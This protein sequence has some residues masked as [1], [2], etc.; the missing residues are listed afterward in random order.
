[1]I[2]D[3]AT[4]K[5]RSTQLDLTKVKWAL[6]TPDDDTGGVLIEKDR[7]IAW[8]HLGT[9]LAETAFNSEGKDY[10]QTFSTKSSVYSPFSRIS[11]SVP[12]E[13]KVGEVPL[14]KSPILLRTLNAF[15]DR[16][17]LGIDAR[18]A[19]VL[20]FDRK[21]FAMTRHSQMIVDLPL[22]PRDP[23]GEPTKVETQILREKL[24]RSLKKIVGKPLLAGVTTRPNYF[25]E[26]GAQFL[27]WS[28]AD[29]FPLFTASCQEQ[30][31]IRC[32]F[33]RACDVTLG[34]NLQ[35]AE[36]SGLAASEKRQRLYVGNRQRQSIEIFRGSSC[37]NLVHE[38]S[39]VLPEQLGSLRN[40]YI[41]ADDRLWVTT[42]SPDNYRNA[43]AYAW[44]SVDW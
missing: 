44:E 30:D 31:G 22:P 43:S 42:Q 13:A 18:D 12:Q 21:T 40:I 3:L 10:K 41:D 11:L 33:S 9:T 26:G 5:N 4:A 6:M 37:L 14:L 28:H 38:G 20:S 23:R 7:I 25:A 27:V 29:L 15:S 19:Q 8:P 24:S 34:K 1:M 36:W 39:I 35:H 17:Y 32:Q 16:I 2:A